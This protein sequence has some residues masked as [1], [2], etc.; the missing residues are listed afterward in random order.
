MTRKMNT[1]EDLI[2][3]IN[4]M[5]K[6]EQLRVFEH[7]NGLL[8]VSSSS[9][10]HEVYKVRKGLHEGQ[11]ITCPHCRSEHWILYGK[12]NGIQ[13]YRCKDCSRIFTPLTGT[14]LHWIHSKDKWNIYMD[15]MLQ[16][17]TLHKCAK[18]AGI[19]YK[20]SFD[21]RHKILRSLKD[22]GCSK[23]TG[24]IE[25]DETFFLSSRK[26]RLKVR[27][28]KPRKRGGT[29]EYGTSKRLCVLTAVD[30]NE[31]LRLNITGIGNPTSEQIT[32]AMD[33][34]ILK[35]KN[36]NKKSILCTDGSNSYMAFAKKKNLTHQ[37]IPG[38]D[39][40]WTKPKVY[41]LQHVNNVHSR[42]KG[43]IRTFHGVSD[44]YLINYL[45]YFRTLETTKKYS[46][47]N[48]RYLELTLSENSVYLPIQ[49]IK[50]Y[51]KKQLYSI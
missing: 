7:I 33:S 2:S 5:P 19:S 32:R 28:R 34:W 36:K 1:I 47:Q 51:Y 9:G 10:E 21:W 3:R 43:W 42:L 40:K 30:R 46:N 26:G 37:K 27:G 16:T 20:T 48:Q 23:L 35:Q 38:Y 4:L 24:I 6:E 29:S 17:M 41:H 11:P 25:A 13:R 22:I 50:E 39:L 18:K 45:S 12:A 14:S 49:A 31:N 8:N 44:K 15:C